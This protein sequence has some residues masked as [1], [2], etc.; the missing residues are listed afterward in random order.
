MASS[1]PT[2]FPLHPSKPSSKPDIPDLSKATFLQTSIHTTQERPPNRHSRSRASTGLTRLRI[3]TCIAERADHLHPPR[4]TGQTS[5]TT[6]CTKSLFG[7]GTQDSDSTSAPIPIPGRQTSPSWPKTPLTAREIEGGHFPFHETSPQKPQLSQSFRPRY[8]LRP[9]PRPSNHIDTLSPD[10]DSAPNPS[11]TPHRGLSSSHYQ[12]S[13]PLSPTMP[14]SPLPLKTNANTRTSK[15]SSKNLHLPSLPRFHPANYQP[16]E[17]GSTQAYRIPR[18]GSSTRQFSDPQQQVH[19][20]QRDI[21]ANATRSARSVIAQNLTTKPSPPR[22]H[23]LGSP[24]P[25]TPMALEEHDD[26]LSVGATEGNQDGAQGDEGGLSNKSI[27]EENE[28]MIHPGLLNKRHSPA[29]S[30]TGGLG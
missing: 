3:D 12:P 23:P 27:R 28:R 4:S 21:V 6:D 20:Y 11:F 8:Q 29:V 17:T 19:Q 26:Y 5:A 14:R 15:H 7:L 13:S 1:L 16:L 2:F 25:V 18:P 22:L 24:G 30:S 9:A 10:S